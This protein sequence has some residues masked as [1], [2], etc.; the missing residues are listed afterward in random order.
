M[1]FL[2]WSH[3]RIHLV[4]KRI[5]ENFLFFKILEF[6][7]HSDTNDKLFCQIYTFL[8]IFDLMHESIA[9]HSKGEISR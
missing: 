6:P 2:W 8:L 9:L 7:T 5:F 1:R 3:I 4:Q